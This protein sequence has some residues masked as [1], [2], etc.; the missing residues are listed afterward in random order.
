[1]SCI[2]QTA[3]RYTARLHGVPLAWPKPIL[4]TFS[5]LHGKPAPFRAGIFLA[6]LGEDMKALPTEWGPNSTSCLWG[7]G[8]LRPGGRWSPSPERFHSRACQ[9]RAAPGSHHLKSGVGVWPQEV[10]LEWSC[11]VPS[12]GTNMRL[13][14]CPTKPSASYSIGRPK[15]S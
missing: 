15:L 8:S 1:M 7:F 11:D 14:Q 9:A 3:R 5:T 10:A 4:P 6:G 12:E 2:D 13:E